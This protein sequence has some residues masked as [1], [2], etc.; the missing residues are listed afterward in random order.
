[1]VAEPVDA[2]LFEGE[3]INPDE[4]IREHPELEPLVKQ[5]QAAFTRKTQ[6]LAEQRRQ[7]EELGDVEVVQQAVDLFHRIQDPANWQSLHADL[8]KAMT[9]MGLTPAE[10]SAEAARQMEEAHDASATDPD[11]SELEKDPELAPLAAMIRK[12]QEQLDSFEQTHRARE[13]AAEAERMHQEMLGNF[14]RQENA[15]REMRTDYK[16]EDVDMVYEMSSFYN[17]NLLDSQ[18]RLEGY[19][20]SRIERYIAEKSGASEQAAPTATPTQATHAERV[21][22]PETIRD[23]EE[24][25]VEYLRNLQKAGELDI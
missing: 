11:L 2:D 25:A 14:T 6:G 19:V 7:F 12:Q 9:Q 18:A 16:D 22:S 5:L 20:Q 21:D 17:G 1:M 24:E 4:L 10:A 23:V 8:T 15:I 3:Q 13:Q